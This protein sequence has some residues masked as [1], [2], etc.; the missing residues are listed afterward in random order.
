MEHKQVIYI[1]AGLFVALVVWQQVQLHSTRKELKQA[2]QQVVD[3]HQI[4]IDSSLAKIE[5]LILVADWHQTRADSLWKHY[6]TL[7]KNE[8][9][10]NHDGNYVAPDANWATI[11][12]AYS[13]HLSR[14]VVRPSDV[15]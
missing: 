14:S 10:I 8:K 2:R 1:V 11:D 12:S 7:E 4:Q 15:E 5:R 6:L 9:D 3:M 13:T